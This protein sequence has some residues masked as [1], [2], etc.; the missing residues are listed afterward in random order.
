MSKR[1]NPPEPPWD[2]FIVRFPAFCEMLKHESERGSVIVGAVLLD[3]ALEQLL[4]R[5]LVPSPE[6]SD[7]LF[8]GSYAPLASFSAKIDFAY[9]VGIIGLHRRSSLHIIRKLRND[10]AHSSLQI[11][12]ESQKVHNKV[13]ELFKLNKALLD[14]IWRTVE[15]AQEPALIDLIGSSKAK[16]GVDYLIRIMGWKSTFEFLAAMI[17]AS[18]YTFEG[19]IEPIVSPDEVRNSR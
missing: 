1:V 4:K 6:K 14:L 7:E 19:D 12:F 16:H 17:T 18:L 9:R 8:K 2:I 15:D 5:K 3:E 13:Q 10:F 11:S